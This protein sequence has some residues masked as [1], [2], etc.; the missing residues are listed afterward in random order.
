MPSDPGPGHPGQLVDPAVLRARARGARDIWSKSRALG[1]GLRSPG[2]AVR[3]HGTSDPSACFQDTWSTPRALGQGH[4]S[5]GTAGR[6]RGPTFKGIV[7]RDSRSTT[8]ALRHERVARDSMLTPR[9]LGHDHM[10]PGRS[11]RPRGHLD[12]IASRP[13]QLVDP[14]GPL[15]R[16]RNTQE[17]WSTPWAL[18]LGPRSPRTAGRTAVPRTR[19]Q[20]SRDSR[21]SLRVFGKGP[22][23][24]G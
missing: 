16:A 5:P 2:T 24:P 11:G 19:A 15:T 10:S 1:H 8:R 7:C 21:S 3:L 9:D 14:V 18:G 6:P 13:G 20:V 4:E 17:I 12:P 22:S 23:G